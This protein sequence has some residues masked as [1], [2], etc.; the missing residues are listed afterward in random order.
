MRI[1]AL[2]IN[3]HLFKSRK[4]IKCELFQHFRRENYICFECLQILHAEYEYA[5]CLWTVLIFEYAMH[6]VWWKSVGYN[7]RKEQFPYLESS[8][9][10]GKK[11]CAPFQKK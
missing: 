7:L 8:D 1:W 5:V 10:N 11:K 6:F 3:I 4:Q 9:F 2:F